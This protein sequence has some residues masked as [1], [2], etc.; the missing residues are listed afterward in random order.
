MTA[1]DRRAPAE[2]AR[3][4]QTGLLR[5]MVDAVGPASPF[6]R[7]RLAALGT[8][9]VQA[10]TPDGL[11][12]LPAVGERD[13]CPDG[14][15]AAAAALVLQT[16]ERGFALHAEGPLLR[17]AL[18][19]R[20]VAPGA[21]AAA[22]ES[23][24]RPTSYVFAGLGLRFPVAS[25]RGDLDVVARAGA[26]LWQV[27]GLDRGDVVVGALPDGA[28]RQALQLGALGAGAPALLVEPAGLVEALRLLPA[29]VLALPSARAAVLVDALLDDAPALRTVLL[30]GAPTA[31]E[32]SD[33]EA[34]VRGRD[35]AV[36]GVHVPD[37]HRLPWAR[38]RA[39]AGGADPGLHTLPDLEV[40]HVV[41]PETAEPSSAGGELV[42]TQ[43]GLRGSA[44]VRWRTGDLVEGIERG[45][46]PACGRTVPRAVGLR[47]RALVPVLSLREG[48]RPVDLRGVAAALAGR[49][50][51][52][53]W[54]VEVGPS[55]RDGADELLVHVAT[56]PGADVAEAV[57]AV[58]RDVRAAAGLLP[59]QVVVAERDDLPDGDG[60]TARVVA[61]R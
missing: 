37:A 27:L 48:D 38:C 34:V 46:C 7:A 57:V 24:T 51:L 6:W 9:P 41:D 43:L 28:E 52:L 58:A 33:V 4:Q 15:P 1:W 36:L 40:L 26:R 55:P 20:L 11:A 56:L 3:A 30:V 44:L 32:Q 50:D 61:D 25:T 59:T 39:S 53:D 5:Q 10:G 18:L 45:P 60:P 13:V 19:R 35:V 31:Q 47:R 54:R 49:P 22:V 23:D 16:G 29:T 42:L 21:Y 17:R 2:Q 14:D 12:A 8:T